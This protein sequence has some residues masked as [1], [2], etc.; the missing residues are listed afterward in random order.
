M[1]SK[2]VHQRHEGLAAD[3]AGARALVPRL[4]GCQPRL[5]LQAVVG[6]V[7]G[8]LT[9]VLVAQANRPITVVTLDRPE[10]ESEAP[11]AKVSLTTCL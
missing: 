7:L 10:G 6:I 11:R 8:R 4:G 1:K 2:I 5:A 3:V 9:G